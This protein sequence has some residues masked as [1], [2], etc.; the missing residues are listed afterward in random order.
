MFVRHLTFAEAKGLLELVFDAGS[1]HIDLLDNNLRLAVRH[2]REEVI[3]IHFLRL[4][5]EI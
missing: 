2:S 3:E 4:V 1:P 5:F